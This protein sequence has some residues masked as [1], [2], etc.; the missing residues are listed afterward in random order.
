MELSRNQRLKFVIILGALT[1]IGPLSIDMYLPG[2]KAI[3]SDLNT[4]MSMVGLSLTSYFFGYSAGQLLYGPLI[5]RFGRKYPLIIGLVLYGLSTLSCAVSPDIYWLIGSRLFL[6]IG[7]CAGVVASRAIVRDYFNITESA[8]FFSALMLVMGLAPIIAPMI[9][10]LIS[11]YLGWRYIF[12]ILFLFTLLL[13]MATSFYLP[14]VKGADKNITLK[15]DNVFKGYMEIFKNPVFLAYGLAGSVTYAS[16]FAYIAG[17][18]FV[19]MK[20]FGLSELHYSWA[21]G[22]NATGLIIGS[23]TN[24]FWLKKMSNKKITTISLL[25]LVIIS[26][27]LFVG[28]QSCLFAPLIS[29]FCIFC[30]IFFLGIINP[31]TIALAMSPFSKNAGSASAL[32]GGIQ[33]AVSALASAIVSSIFNGTALPMVI[34]MASCAGLGLI[35]V[36]IHI[37]NEQKKYFVK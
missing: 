6:S 33:M 28:I 29:M 22:I 13:L 30:F 11:V 32:M 10:S 16:M 3:A 18:P 14:P 19:Y 17:S 31:N 15:L 8:K 36:S 7:G 23:Q 35:I 34:G 9:G 5:D 27:I 2:F 24:R 21:F 20:V 12:Y 26:I 37:M 4:N 25:S 1:A